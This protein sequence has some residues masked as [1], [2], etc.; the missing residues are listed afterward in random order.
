MLLIA[1]LLLTFGAL[2]AAQRLYCQLLTTVLHA[3]MSFFDTTPMGRILNRF[4]K[5]TYMI[6]DVIPTS[7]STFIAAVIRILATLIII[8]LS[9]PAFAAVILPVA[10]VYYLVQVRRFHI[11]SSENHLLNLPNL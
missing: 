5:D 10:V 6:D 2:H 11:V 4:S 9:T 1:A 3:P 7:L 8:T